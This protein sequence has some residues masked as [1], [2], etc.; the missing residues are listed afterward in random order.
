M[1]LGS[2]LGEGVDTWLS[3]RNLLLIALGLVLL[4]V[5]GTAVFENTIFG[6]RSDASPELVQEF[7]QTEVIAASLFTDYLLS[8]QLVAVFTIGGG[9]RGSVVG[10]TPAATTFPSNYCCTRFHLGRGEPT[11][12]RRYAAR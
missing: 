9:Y 11:P 4:T 1:L 6:A 5:V 3:G 12:Q 7:G 8:F 10:P 2:D